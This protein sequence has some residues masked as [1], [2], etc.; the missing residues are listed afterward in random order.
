MAVKFNEHLRRLNIFELEALPQ[1]PQQ[2]LL[3]PVATR[4][5]QEVGMQEEQRDLRVEIFPVVS[6][7]SHRRLGSAGALR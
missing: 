5:V 7:L 2:P 6:T 1:V 4:L 3:D